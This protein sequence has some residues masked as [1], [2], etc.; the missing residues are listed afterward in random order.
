M[1]HD[2]KHNHQVIIRKAKHGDMDQV[3][4]VFQP[5]VKTADTYV[6]DPDTPRRDL[7]KHWFGSNMFTYVAEL[8]GHIVGTYIL[9]PNQIDLGSHIANGSYM[10]HPD[11][12]NKGI[13]RQMAIHSIKEARKLG[14]KAMQFNMVI[15][16][17]KAAIHLWETLGFRIIGTVPGA[18]FYKKERYVGVHIMYKNLES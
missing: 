11:A 13:G 14:F 3:W 1:K 4:N 5:V 17:N 8:D 18:L 10:V 6:F 2:N 16:T 9:K 15:E 12:W 7:K